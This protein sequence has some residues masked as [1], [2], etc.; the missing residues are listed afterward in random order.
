MLCDCSHRSAFVRAH[1]ADC[2]RP[3]PQ[4]L[5]EIAGMVQ[6]IHSPGALFV[7]QCSSGDATPDTVHPDSSEDREVSTSAVP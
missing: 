2:P 5:E 3:E 4:V 7:R 6:I 1:G